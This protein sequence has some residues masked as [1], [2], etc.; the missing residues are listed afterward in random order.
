YC[1]IAQTRD[2]ANCGPLLTKA[3]KMLSDG[4]IKDR[5]TTVLT[6]I[7]DK[8]DSAAQIA[9]LGYPY[10]EGDA[11]YT[12]RSGHGA[13]TFIKVGKRLRK[14]GDSGVPGSCSRRRVVTS[15]G[16]RM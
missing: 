4:T 10:L 12:L 6:A 8:A 7:R 2:G 13:K 9:L 16:A 3:E 14:I 5:L 1:L 15:W 11:G